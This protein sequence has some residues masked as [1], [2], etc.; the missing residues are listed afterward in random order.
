VNEDIMTFHWRGFLVFAAFAAVLSIA[1][2]P[3]LGLLALI[4]YG[5]VE[6]LLWGGVAGFGRPHDSKRS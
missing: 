2:E 3:G 5:I 1:V 4:A 6:A